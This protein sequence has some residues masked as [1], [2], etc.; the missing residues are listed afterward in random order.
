ML[1]DSKVP[2]NG[3]QM[4]LSGAIWVPSTDRVNVGF[5]RRKAA[6]SWAFDSSIFNLS[7][8][9]FGLLT[10][11]R[12]TTFSH[13]QGCGVCAMAPQH[14]RTSNAEFSQIAFRMHYPTHTFKNSIDTTQ[15][16]GFSQIMAVLKNK[17]RKC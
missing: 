7:A 2:V 10:S 11:N 16:S 17:L 14:S 6:I 12:C 15:K 4:P 8:N 9:K 13:V 1:G 3:R 5:G